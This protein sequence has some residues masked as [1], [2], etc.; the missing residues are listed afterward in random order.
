MR[1]NFKLS[2]P[3]PVIVQA[4]TPAS[5]SANYRAMSIARVAMNATSQADAG[6]SWNNGFGN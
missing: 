3:T 6:F 1:V 2:D 4:M 5:G